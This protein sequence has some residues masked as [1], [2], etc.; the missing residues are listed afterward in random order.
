MAFGAG[1]PLLQPVIREGV[2]DGVLQ[3]LSSSIPRRDWERK[4][5]PFRGQRDEDSGFK[6]KVCLQSN[7]LLQ[8]KVHL[9]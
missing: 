2:Y 8:F 4:F 9:Y 7:A 3:R 1:P 5:P 6:D